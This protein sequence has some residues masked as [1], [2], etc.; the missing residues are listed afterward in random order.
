MLYCHF[1]ATT[2]V[3]SHLIFLRI[4]FC[5]NIRTGANLFFNQYE[6]DPELPIPFNARIKYPSQFIISEPVDT[7][8][9]ANLVISQGVK[10]LNAP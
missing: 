2:S 3:I 4:E 10:I 9:T 7:S 6:K 5:P 8:C 1:Q